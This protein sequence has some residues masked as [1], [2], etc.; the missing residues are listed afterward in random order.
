VLPVRN[1]TPEDI[2]RILWYRKW[3]LLAGMICAA[4]AGFGASLQIPNE[5]RSETLIL[6]IP[7][8]VPES[9]VHSTVTMRIE[10]RLRSISQEI[11]SRSRLEKII[12]EFNLYP[13][14]QKVRPME[15]IVEYM[16]TNISVETVRDDAFRVS[17]SDGAPRTA[18]IVTDRLA[19]MFIDENS[20]D[21]SVMADST[22]QFLESQLED[23]R[24]RLVT[25]ERKLEEF[26][27]R[28][29]GELPSQLQTNLQV[30][31][32]T[33]N[34]IRALS[35]S[36]NRD[37]DRRLVLERSISDAQSGNTAS[38]LLAQAGSADG[39]ATGPVRAADQLEKAR[40]ELRALEL[41]LKPEHPDVIAKKR[42]VAELEDKAQEEASAASETRATG[43]RPASATDLLRQAR[44]RQDQIEMEKLDRQIAT[45][46]AEADQLRRAVAG[47]Q[48]KVE[49]VPGHESELTDLMRDYDTLQKMYSSLLAKKEDSKISANLERQQ[50]SEQFKILDRARLPERPFSPNRVRMTAIA[51]TVGL[52]LAIGLAA[53]MEYRTTALRTEDEIVRWLVLP[54]LA[55]IPLMTSAAEARRRRRLMVASLA[56]TIVVVLGIATVSLKHFGLLKGIL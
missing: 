8:R 21:R 3:I 49:A 23:A 41:R 25:H 54:V 43:A 22:N 40:A 38:D 11:L 18:M 36:I 6:V 42:A 9:Y 53:F 4:A 13:D 27:R 47:Y 26:R 39:S 30:I 10:D 19:S 20:R 46:E 17:F 15:S 5:Y 55:A 31:Q 29:S 44:A 33:E 7:Q 1:Y 32:S 48:H 2:V 45:K 16:R 51:A 50:V 56:A 34:Q 52:A 35:E 12:D 28:Y 14:L 24:Q 37:H